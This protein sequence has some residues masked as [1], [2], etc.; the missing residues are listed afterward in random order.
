MKI[1]KY[2]EFESINESI[3]EIDESQYMTA[4]HLMEYL[5]KNIPRNTLIFHQGC[6]CPIQLLKKSDIDDRL[7]EVQDIYLYET[8]EDSYPRKEYGDEDGKYNCYEKKY[9]EGTSSFENTDKEPKVVKGI[10]LNKYL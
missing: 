2:S 5:R 6:D 4:G 8:K 7:P 3:V 9:P 1:K 10:I